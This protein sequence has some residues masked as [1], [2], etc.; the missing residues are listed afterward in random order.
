MNCLTC[1]KIRF[2]KGDTSMCRQAQ[3]LGRTHRNVEIYRLVR[4]G[5]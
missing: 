2:Y 3:K 4:D 1:E 5:T